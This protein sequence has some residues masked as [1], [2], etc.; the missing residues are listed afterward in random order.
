MSHFVFWPLTPEAER[1]AARLHAEIAALTMRRAGWRLAGLLAKANFDPGQPRVPAGSGDQSGRWAQAG[2]QSYPRKPKKNR[3][4]SDKI[5]SGAVTY[6]M[7]D[8]T[9]FAAPPGIDFEKIHKA[10]QGI[11]AL[12]IT[13]WYDYVKAN[14]GQDGAF[15]VQRTPSIVYSKYADAA[16]FAAGVFMNGAGASKTMTD[17]VGS[18]YA[19]LL[20]KGGITSARLKFWNSGYDA[21]ASGN[22]PR[23]SGN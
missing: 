2:W 10:G 9:K 3:I 1:Q 20:S 7:G 11:H 18:L 6:T 14:I 21:A 12:P 4:I 8:G 15:D 19:L 23:R 5:P 22:W 16:N 17:T 13:Q